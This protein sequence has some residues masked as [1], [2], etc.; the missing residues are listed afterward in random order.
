MLCNFDQCLWSIKMLCYLDVPAMYQQ[1]IEISFL[2]KWNLHKPYQCPVRM[3][4]NLFLSFLATSNEANGWT[5]WTHIFLKLC[6]HWVRTRRTYRVENMKVFSVAAKHW[7]Q[8]EWAIFAVHIWKA[9][10]EIAI[11]KQLMTQI[12]VKS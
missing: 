6:V 11:R 4:K 2:M 3:T 9:K 12:F 5:I 8:S 10:G 7:Q 1:P